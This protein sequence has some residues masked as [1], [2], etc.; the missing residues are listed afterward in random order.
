MRGVAA[1][2]FAYLALGCLYWTGSKGGWLVALA[3]CAV[4]LLRAPIGRKWRMVLIVVGLV[5]GL[6]LFA[7][8]FSA[9]FQKGAPSVGARFDYWSAAAK[10]FQDRPIFGS[11]P[12]TFQAAYA[13]IKPPEAEMT[14]LAHNDYIEQASD[15]GLP[16]FVSYLAF[17]GG[18]LI[19]V[20]RRCRTV[21]HQL[22]W[23][24]LLGWA[25]QGLMEFGLYIPALAWP[26]FFFMGWLWSLPAPSSSE[27]ISG[28]ATP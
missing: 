2:L 10:T 24:G 21:E 7:I 14:R 15:S 9:Y 18:T 19:L 17:I 27:P 6:S 3:L 16:G 28:R 11:G 4:T 22:V 1:G 23:L 20:Y 8:R 12:G 25:L 13:R 5:L 26:A